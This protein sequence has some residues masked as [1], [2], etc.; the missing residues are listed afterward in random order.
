MV[1]N[2]ETTFTT[3][4]KVKERKSK[5]ERIVV[6]SETRPAV[7]FSVDYSG[8]KNEQLAAASSYVNRFPIGLFPVV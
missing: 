5:R 2:N 8:I 4:S 7:K 6:E 3:A 1:L